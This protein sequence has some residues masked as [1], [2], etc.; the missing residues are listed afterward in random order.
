MNEPVFL[1]LALLAGA[2]LGAIFFGGLWWTVRKGLSSTRPAIW[3]FG[4]LL[5]RTVL[6][7]GGFYFIGRDQWERLAVCLIGFVIARVGVMRLTRP[8]K[9][10]PA[11]LIK[12][13]NDAP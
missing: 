9:T 12:E 1:G 2:A 7:L 8:V 13:V 6:V 10:V 5:L 11:N 4:S 3:V